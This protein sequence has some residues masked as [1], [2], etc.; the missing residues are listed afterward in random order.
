MTSQMRAEILSIPDVVSRQIAE[1]G[2]LYREIGAQLR[3]S[4][5]RAAISNARG[6]SDHAAT[7]LKYLLEMLVGLPLASVGPS[8]VSVYGSR[9]RL[10]GQ[11][12][13]TISQSGASTDLVMLQDAATEAGALT[14][15]LVNDTASQVALKAA[16]L[17]PLHAGPEHAVAATKSFVASLVAAAT[18]AAAWSG[19]D[20]V[21]DAF[22]ALPAALASS[23]EADWS[24]AVEPVAAASS[25]FT[26]SRGPAVA[27]AAEA[28][29]KFK[30]TC[31]LHAEP[32]SA[33]E[34]LHGPIALPGP[35]FAALVFASRDQGRASIVKARDALAA[36]G[37][38]VYFC[39]YGAT[40]DLRLEPAP[41]PLLDPICAIA[42][43]YGF[44][45]TVA[46]A[47][48]LDPDKPPHLQKV[49]VTR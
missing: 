6:T 41:H 32:F 30:E 18:I 35:R 13:V 44:V 27:A 4:G 43:F 21:L 17:A 47:R 1:A 11:L 39:D 48:D 36:T 23:I 9:L 38:T 2:P 19:A 33:A 16:L 3:A 29:L 26:V 49:T 14:L 46:R 7:Y 34:L 12:C 8:I 40:G 5:V 37:A 25:V 31:R 22:D 15:A 24:A 42:S 28:A 20:D 45:E 10:D